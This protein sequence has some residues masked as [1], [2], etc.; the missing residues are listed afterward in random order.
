MLGQDSTDIFD[1]IDEGFG[2]ALIPKM[3]AHLGHN[4]LPEAV[5]AFSVNGFVA[6]DG[7]FVRAGRDKDEDGIPVARFVH[8]Q[9]LKSFSRRSQRIATQLSTLNVNANFARS[10][11]LGLS[12]G[13]HDAIV[14]ELAQEFLGTHFT[15]STRRPRP[16]NF[17]RLRQIR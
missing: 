14:L 11:D 13:A 17:L 1:G 8:P 3:F 6:D 16:Q 15:S 2:K 4:T 5:A 12:N 9:S 7:E 10:S